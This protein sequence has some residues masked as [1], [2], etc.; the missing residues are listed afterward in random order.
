[1]R[2]PKYENHKGVLLATSLHTPSIYLDQE[3]PQEAVTDMLFLQRDSWEYLRNVF[4]S[5]CPGICCLGTTLVSSWVGPLLK[6]SSTLNCAFFNFLKR[7]HCRNQS[8]T[9]TW[10]CFFLK[11]SNRPWQ[12]CPGA[13]AWITSWD[14]HPRRNSYGGGVQDM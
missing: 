5:Q 4:Y 6:A 9:W 2:F 13:V 7:R 11:N 1:M 14:S 8:V 3:I 12:H 10:R